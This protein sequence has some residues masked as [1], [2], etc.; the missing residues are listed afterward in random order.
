MSLFCLQFLFETFLAPVTNKPIPHMSDFIGTQKGTYVFMWVSVVVR[1]Q[2][3]LVRV[4]K[5]LAKVPD[6]WFHENLFCGSRVVICSQRDMWRKQQGPFLRFSVENSP[7][8]NIITRNKRRREIECK[9]NEN[10]LIEILCSSLRAAVRVIHPTYPPTSS[11]NQKPRLTERLY[12]LDI[13]W[14]VYHFAIYI[15]SNKIHNVFSTNKF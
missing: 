2:P 8:R 12:R 10:V 9:V 6:I 15:W 1:F 13:V 7:T 4:R 11:K 3:N 14:S 5:V